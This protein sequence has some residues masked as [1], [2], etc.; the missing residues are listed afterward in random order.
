[1]EDRLFQA[2]SPFYRNQ[3]R[4]AA[5]RWNSPY[6]QSSFKLVSDAP[7]YLADDEPVVS[8]EI[9]GEAKAYPLA[10]L[11]W[12]E[13][14]NDELG[15]IPVTVTFC[16]LCNTA[17][18]FDRRLDGEVF[19][20]GTSGL[21]RNSDLVM[22]DRQTESWWQQITGEAIVGELTGTKLTF[23]PA[24][25]ISWGDFRE[26][27]PQG[28][29]LTR[30]T[31]FIRNYASPPYRGYDE[32]GSTPFLFSGEIDDRLDAMER[33][34]GLAIDGQNMAYPFILLEA[35]PVIND[36]VGGQELVVFYTGGT[37]SAFAGRGVPNRVVGSTGMYVPFVEGQKLT[38]KIQDALIVDEETGSK[39]NILGQ[40]V[41][42]PLEGS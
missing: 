31:G 30:E 1:M 21:L 15:G 24:N 6:R 7:E 38:F 35:N 2:F 3:V 36:T 8:L 25:V 14:V 37:L 26:I 39:W 20:F 18:V 17:I 4:R 9:D 5:T 22:W 28:Q 33:V 40:A 19:D 10:I 41:E 16:P 27:H 42:G 13:I 23:I 34:V 11:M 12:H 29:V 32:I